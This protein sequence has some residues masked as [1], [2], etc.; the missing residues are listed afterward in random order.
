MMQ[1]EEKGI[2]Q[3]K[4]RSQGKNNANAGQDKGRKNIEKSFFKRIINFS[5]CMMKD[6][7]FKQINIVVQKHLVLK[8]NVF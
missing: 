3:E 2:A 7:L 4:K 5:S 8:T 6:L 1:R